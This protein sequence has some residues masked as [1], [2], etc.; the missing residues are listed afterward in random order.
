MTYSPSKAAVDSKAVF[1][2]A[3]IVYALV[4]EEINSINGVGRA[5]PERAVARS[6]SWGEE[7]TVSSTLPLGTYMAAAVLP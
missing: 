6:V 5:P 4:G 2:G 3:K 1:E 7:K